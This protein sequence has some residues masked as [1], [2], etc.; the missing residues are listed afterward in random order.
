M[1]APLLRTAVAS[2]PGIAPAAARSGA[3]PA[4]PATVAGKGLGKRYD[5][6]VVFHRLGFSWTGPGIV[7]VC[8]PNGSGKSTLLSLMA[9]ASEPD[10]GDLHILGHSMAHAREQAL[11][12]VS[13]VPDAC[14]VYP[15]VTGREWLAFVRAARR[16][17]TWTAPAIASAFGLDPS[18]DLRFGAMSLGTARKVLLAAGLG[19]DAPVVLL[20]EP[21]SGLDA[22][23]LAVLRQRLAEIAARG[24][25][26]MCCHDVDEQRQLGARCVDLA[27]LEAPA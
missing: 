3:S 22:A 6:R 8:G 21:T 25:V 13:Y 19:T 12:L 15:F 11:P 18:L 16:P 20:D 14:P 27:S 26:V 4:A 17:A 5:D 2:R 1:N 7:C 24:L 10:H 23:A 9:G